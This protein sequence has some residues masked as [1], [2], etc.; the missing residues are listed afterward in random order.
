MAV[1]NPYR[2]GLVKIKNLRT[3]MMSTVEYSRNAI[4]WQL[5]CNDGFWPGCPALAAMDAGEALTGFKLLSFYFKSDIVSL[6]SLEVEP[7][8]AIW[9]VALLFTGCAVLWN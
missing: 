4:F 6:Y 8:E 5:C 9:V 3:V 2:F 7:P 1:H